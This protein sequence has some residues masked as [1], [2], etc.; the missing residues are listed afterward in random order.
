M[1]CI[2][3]LRAGSFTYS[4]LKPKIMEREAA[5]EHVQYEG[6]NEW[7]ACLIEPGDNFAIVCE[8]GN[9]N[10]LD[11]WLVKCTQPKHVVEKAF[12]DGWGAN[13]SR[14]EHIITGKYY[15]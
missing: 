14:K 10:K 13:F 3:L 4:Q 5:I 7:K 15:E 11:F 8:P 2:N 9:K 1:S 12:I 6:D